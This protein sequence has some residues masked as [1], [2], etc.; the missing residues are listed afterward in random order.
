MPTAEWWQHVEPVA[1]KSEERRA[2]LWSILVKQ[3]ASILARSLPTEHLQFTVP[4]AVTYHC[5]HS[6]SE[7]S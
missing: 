7:N 6:R 1:S 3:L 4:I 5:S 2:P